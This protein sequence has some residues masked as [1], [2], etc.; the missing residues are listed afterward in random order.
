MLQT[1]N[2]DA[3]L[4]DLLNSSL[5]KI[6]QYRDPDKALNFWISTFV[7]IYDKHAPIRIQRV[8]HNP[9]PPWITEEIL[10]EMKIRDQFKA[11]NSVEF[12]EQ[13]NKVTSII[14]KAK[15]KY[16][17][18]LISNNK[19]PKSVWNAI[20][21]L[22]NKSYHKPQ[23][24]SK[25]IAPET[26]NNHFTS[27]A[28]TLITNDEWKRNGLEQLIKYCTSKNINSKLS[29]PYITMPEVYASLI[30]LKQSGT[31]DIHELDGKIIKLS[32]TI[33]TES[34]TYLY[35]L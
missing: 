30:S 4:D 15:Y 14:R 22:T 3:F 16:Y 35:N 32:A 7:E 13:R 12:K 6:Y 8:K 2:K 26:I 28:D 24:N 34:L 17:Q 10:K 23:P 29:I 27:I 11:K 33:I 20:N 21:K 25:D 19:N 5:S 18:E 31:K 9:K 1:F